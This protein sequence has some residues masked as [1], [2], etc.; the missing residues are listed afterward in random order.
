VTAIIDEARIAVRE[1]VASAQ[2]VDEA[3]CL[4]T[5]YPRGPIAWEREVGEARVERI[6]RWV[7]GER[8]A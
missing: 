7:N 1:R 4:G 6:L 3:M 5:N 8:A 2:D